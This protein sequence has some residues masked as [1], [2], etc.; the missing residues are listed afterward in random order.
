M[1]LETK[2]EIQY[3]I[4]RISKIIIISFKRTRENISKRMDLNIVKNHIE[5]YNL[6]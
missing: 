4:D 1:K 2:K 3:S 5:Q 6:Y